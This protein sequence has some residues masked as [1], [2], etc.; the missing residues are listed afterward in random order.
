MKKRKQR[1]LVISDTHCGHLTG[2]TPP[3]FQLNEFDKSRTKRN[4]W[5]T[6]QK[7]SWREFKKLLRRYEPFDLGFHLGDLIDGKGKRSGGVELIT[8]SMDEQAGMAASV[9]N[10]VRLHANKGFEW[11]G[12]SGTPYHTDADGDSWDDVAARRAGFAKFGSH[13]WITVN[14]CTFD[15]KHKIGSSSVP[16]GKGTAIAKSRLHNL[17]WAE[18]QPKADVVIRG[19]THSPFF[20]GEPGEWLGVICPALQGWTKYGATQCEGR[21]RWGITIFDVNKDGSYDWHSDIITTNSQKAVAVI[22]A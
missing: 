9:C 14:G 3:A 22:H 4:K 16:Y 7:E 21:V 13:E 10:T 12:V 6:M 2:L 20:C 8:T 5:A 15:L 18:M 19:H 17:L 11:Y 1:I